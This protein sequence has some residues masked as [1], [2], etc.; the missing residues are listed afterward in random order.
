MKDKFLVG[1]CEDLT[2]DV[3]E[4]KGWWCIFA[5][6]DYRNLEFTEIESIGGWVVYG[7]QKENWRTDRNSGSGRV[8][9]VK[10][11]IRRYLR[12]T[13]DYIVILA[14]GIF[15]PEKQKPPTGTGNVYSD[16]FWHE[17]GWTRMTVSSCVWYMLRSD[18]DEWILHRR[19]HSARAFR[20]T[21]SSESEAI[22]RWRMVSLRQLIVYD[23]KYMRDPRTHD[24]P[25]PRCQTTCFVSP[26]I[27]LRDSTDQSTIP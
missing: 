2:I 25:N 7:T 5:G 17:D 19:P 23:W 12:H 4:V 13:W 20:S 8:R 9:G 22:G 16:W 21:L 14:S 3:R 6:H 10:V 11:S 24:C 15:T 26:V 27:S 1:Q 18:H